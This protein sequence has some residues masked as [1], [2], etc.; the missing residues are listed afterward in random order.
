MAF[1]GLAAALFVASVIG[2]FGVGYGKGSSS[3]NPE[4]AEY[5]AAIATS[6][7]LAQEA[8]ARGAQIVER[9][10]VVYK[11]RVKI[12]KEQIPGDIQLVE[13]VKRD[14]TCLAP[15]SFRLLHDR[16]AFGGQDHQGSPGTDAA[17][18]PIE[19]I[20]ATVAENYRTYAETAARLD[21]LQTII[22][23]QS[24]NDH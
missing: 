5:Q 24:G 21:A 14:S 10:V 6:K 17:P 1:Y 20:A 18:V 9:E 16:A 4:I 12:I 23:S 13:I 11:D 15:P 7:K 3:R 2:A 19:D 8:E 22:R